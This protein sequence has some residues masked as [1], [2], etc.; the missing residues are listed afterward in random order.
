MNHHFLDI[1]TLHRPSS[2]R[3]AGSWLSPG[4]G[5]AGL[6]EGS[7][8]NG[9][10]G[11]VRHVPYLD[12][13][14]DRSLG[15]E[16][17]PK[18][19][20]QGGVRKAL[21]HTA[22]QHCQLTWFLSYLP[23]SSGHGV[24]HAV[25]DYGLHRDLSPGCGRE[26]QHVLCSPLDAVYEGEGAPAGTVRRRGRPHAVAH[27]VADQGHGAREQHRDKHFVSVD[28]RRHGPVLLVDHLGH[29]EVFEEVH[30]PVLL[31]LG[32]DSSRFGR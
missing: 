29:D 5:H 13:W 20:D 15:P 21:T 27:L 32:G 17:L 23:S 18:R 2:D 25:E 3:V 11:D 19:V 26:A 30:A 24:H 10:A 7:L 31:T 14:Y 28:A 12:R 16:L 9:G 6:D 8:A 4:P 22:K 1:L